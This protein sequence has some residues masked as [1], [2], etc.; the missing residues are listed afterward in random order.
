MTNDM[1]KTL[2]CFCLC[3]AAH[4]A[5]Q[6]YRA[7]DAGSDADSRQGR[8]DMALHSPDLEGI[9]RYDE[10]SVSLST[11]EITPSIPLLRFHDPDFDFPVEA[12]YSA[13][14][15]VPTELDGQLG[16]HWQLRLGGVIVR[17]IRGI[18]DESM[19]TPQTCRG[20]LEV[21]YHHFDNETMKRDILG[22]IENDIHTKLDMKWVRLGVIDE[23]YAR[24][25]G[26]DIEPSSDLYRFSFGRHSG[27]FMIDF[28]GS[29]RVVADGG[30][31]YEID[32]SGFN[33]VPIA[34]QGC[35]EIVIITD[36]GY[37]Y[38]FG[39]SYA[40][41]EYTAY[42]WREGYPW[43]AD[44][45]PAHNSVTAF[46]LTRIVAPNGRELRID[47]DDTVAPQFHSQPYH[48]AEN[49]GN[50]P[51][52]EY[53]Y[54]YSLSAYADLIHDGAYDNL[55]LDECFSLKKIA[56]MRSVETDDKRIDFSYSLKPAGRYHTKLSIANQCGVRL[57]ELIL[58]S[59]TGDGSV[60]C[61]FGYTRSKGDFPRDFLTRIETAQDGAYDFDYVGLRDRNISGPMT[62][63]IDFWG[64]WRGLPECRYLIPRVYEP[65]Y[66]HW[67]GTYEL[68]CE[69]EERQPTGN[70][71]DLTLLRSI[72]FP[73]GGRAEF[74]Y[75]MNTYYM[76]C[77]QVYAHAY[78]RTAR[79]DNIVPI[80]RA[81][82]ARIR[83]IAYYD[84][85]GSD[86]VKKLRYQ[87]LE[88]DGVTS[89]GI[90]TYKPLFALRNYVDRDF[91]PDRQPPI[92]Y[93]YLP[94]YSSTGFKT[95]QELALN[96][97]YRTVREYLVEEDRSAPP[98]DSVVT[99]RLDSSSGVMTR[100]FEIM[101]QSH[102]DAYERMFW[103]IMGQGDPASRASARI[104][105][106]NAGGAKVY[107]YIFDDTATTRG[108]TKVRWLEKLRNPTYFDPLTYLPEGRYR[109]V[110]TR[111]DRTSARFEV[112][113]KLWEKDDIRGPYREMHFTNLMTNPDKIIHTGCFETFPFNSIKADWCQD[114]ALI[115]NFT[116]PYDDRSYERGKL[117]DETYYTAQG[118]P[119]K[120]TEY[121]YAPIG[122]QALACVK[123][124]S[125]LYFQLGLA[126]YSHVS[127][128]TLG[129]Y[130]P[131]EI[132][133]TEYDDEGRA[134]V[135]REQRR[136]SPEGYLQ[137]TRTSDSQ[138][139]YYG[140]DYR[141][142]FDEPDYPH[143]H[144]KNIVAP[145]TQVHTYHYDGQTARF[146]SGSEYAYGMF[147]GTGGRSFCACTRRKEYGS[148]GEV[149]TLVEYADYDRYGN[150][151][152]YLDRS[153]GNMPRVCLWGNEGQHLLARID[154]ATLDE[155]RRALGDA[156]PDLNDVAIERIDSLRQQLP[157]ARV[158]S[159]KYRPLLGNIGKTT[160]PSGRETW[161]R[162][163]DQGRWV[164]SL[165][166]NE[167]G[168][169]I[170]R[171]R[172]VY[173][174]VNE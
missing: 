15:F 42:S 76:S 24:I 81:G 43:H 143:L 119:V 20:F 97:Q 16:M 80:S 87:Y 7:A 90:L 120:K 52:P 12:M 25:K 70:D 95:E 160:D 2:L 71:Y 75:E 150:P 6:N 14:G 30:G 133:T 39:G 85:V 3:C 138:G 163:D 162:Y 142:I 157:Y 156:G 164:E 106:Y 54:A 9:A 92:N 151:L 130:L 168:E 134:L 28:D 116:M 51:S 17:E 48:I 101:V 145:L 102:Q 4:A 127:E 132:T 63:N 58:S 46:Y 99:Y 18:P 62:P 64:Y 165:G 23:F 32:L 5:A 121:R 139:G 49:N 11:G 41:M 40:A 86:P 167:Y 29:V 100:E 126:F 61:R 88:S 44:Y 166:R 38:C 59:K 19:G 8:I 45:V 118:N 37:R 115:R 173:H 154:G 158:T 149:R 171:Q 172:N 36:D 159:Y 68:V 82:G 33:P 124:P 1:K 129:M 96:I 135:R 161:F 73:T 111:A 146:I 56:L 98:R 140:T 84:A 114:P 22:G 79:A 131:V 27:R 93:S 60:R 31:R 66:D 141:R 147:P 117:L 77:E 125:C 57:D 10:T 155:V 69:G 47:Y 128:Q 108:E 94:V 112:T 137:S 107:D 123:V 153:K 89:S 67:S 55:P 136:Y 21:K 105:I 170:L 174:Y 74:G 104:E 78:L 144:E 83:D 152:Y 13:S 35:S 26:T 34:D 110:M 91:H 148:G 169:R 103:R 50:P 72:R 113:Y 65:N 53:R 122:E 109:V